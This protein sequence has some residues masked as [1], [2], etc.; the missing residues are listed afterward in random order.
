MRCLSERNKEAVLLRWYR[1]R[2]Q[3]L[4]VDFISMEEFDKKYKRVFGKY[5]FWY[6]WNHFYRDHGCVGLTKRLS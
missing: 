2:R 6:S 5:P 3:V 4:E 1:K